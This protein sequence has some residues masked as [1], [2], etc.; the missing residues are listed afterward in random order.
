MQNVRLVFVLS[1][2]AKASCSRF[3]LYA[4]EKGLPIQ[5]V[6]EARRIYAN[7]HVVVAYY[8]AAFMPRLIDSFCYL[9]ININKMPVRGGVVGGTTDGHKEKTSTAGDPGER[10]HTPQHVGAL[11]RRAAHAPDGLRTMR[12]M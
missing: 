4:A 9:I 10:T 3:G 8:G 5:F 7:L 1:N 6:K 12:T 11:V 2:R